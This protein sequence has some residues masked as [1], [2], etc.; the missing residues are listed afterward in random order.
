MRAKFV[1]EKFK[2]ESDP[3]KDLNI[4][5]PEKQINTKSW[6]ILKFIESKGEEG[7]SLKEIQ[8]FIWTELSGYSDKSFWEKNKLRPNQ[9][10]YGA[11]LQRKTR[12]FWNTNLLGSGGPYYRGKPGL[13]HKYCKKSEVT[14]KWVLERM[15]KPNEK[16]YS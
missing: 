2:E 15:P 11:N 5:Y 10:K 3:I 7:A 9:Y 8:Y 12:G 4:G 14:H 1:F 6:K 13:L 16:F